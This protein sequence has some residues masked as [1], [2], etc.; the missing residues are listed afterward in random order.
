M[1][2]TVCDT[3]VSIFWL[4][5]FFKDEFKNFLVILFTIS[6]NQVSFTDTALSKNGPNTSWVVISVNPVTDVFT[7]TIKFWFNPWQ[8]VGDLT[9]NEFF[10]V[11][12]WSIVVWAVW[13]S[14]LNTKWTHPCF[15]DKVW[16]SL[17]WWV[18]WWWVV[19]CFCCEF[20]TRTFTVSR[21]I[22]AQW[23]VTINFVCWHV[24][25][26]NIIFTSSFQ[27]C[28]STNKVCVDKWWWVVQWIIIVAFSCI[29]NDGISL[30]SQFINQFSISN[31]TNNQF[32]TVTKDFFNVGTVT[33]VSEF[34]KDSHMYVW[35]VV[36]DIVYEVWTDETCATSYDDIF[37]FSHFFSK[38]YCFFL[39]VP[40]A[41]EGRQQPF[42]FMA[43]SEAEVSEFPYKIPWGN[44]VFT[45]VGTIL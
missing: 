26:T 21:E 36:V 39:I 34:V 19:F 11:L 35:M 16:S 24:V 18:W 20:F 25:E 23:K 41:S 45:R 6:T 14:C 40:F 5:H 8:D 22:F 38:K 33:S 12:V 31:I 9:W 10:D 28:V 3:V 43:K 13:N 15:N 44:L 37:I 27:E 17:S 7:F 42:D 30:S 1:T 2:S 4:T 32:N 29:V